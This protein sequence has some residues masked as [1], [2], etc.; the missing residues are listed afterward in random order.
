VPEVPDR[1]GE[2]GECCGHPEPRGIR[3]R[4]AEGVEHVDGD[5]EHGSADDRPHDEE[6]DHREHP[7]PAVAATEQVDEERGRDDVDRD[8]ERRLDDVQLE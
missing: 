4:A 3:D 6:H 1:E 2:A 5:P 8:E 7:R